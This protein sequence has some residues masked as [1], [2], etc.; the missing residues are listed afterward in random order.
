MCTLVRT[1]NIFMAISLVRLIIHI[2]N[3]VEKG[4]TGGYSWSAS[5]H[6]WKYF[7]F[8][9][10]GLKCTCAPRLILCSSISAPSILGKNLGPL[11]DFYCKGD[12]QNSNHFKAHCRG[13]VKMHLPLQPSDN[14]TEQQFTDGRFLA[15]AVPILSDSISHLILSFVAPNQFLHTHWEWLK[16]RRQKWEKQ[17]KRQRK[18]RDVSGIISKV[19]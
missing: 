18:M 15:L 6:H 10:W 7:Y 12:M 19:A 4:F 2:E 5:E 11:W 9:E 3:I 14:S 1:K 16:K 8:W 17:W 13:C